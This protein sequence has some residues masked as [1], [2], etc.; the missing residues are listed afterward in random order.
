[1]TTVTKRNGQKQTYDENKVHNFVSNLQKVSPTLH[2]T[3]LSEIFPLQGVPSNV[4]STELSKLA[5]ET[6]AA[7]TTTH[8]QYGDLAGRILTANLHKGVPSTFSAAMQKLGDT[9]LDRDFLD[10]VTANEDELNAMVH[11]ERDFSF[12]VFAFATLERSYLLRNLSDRSVVETPQYLWLRVATA[13]HLPNMQ[14][15]EHTYSMLSTKQFTHATPTLFNSGCRLQQLASCFLLDVEDSIDGIYSTLRDCAVISKNAG[16]LGINISKIRATG[17]PIKG[18]NGVSNGIVPM[19]KVFE[20]T[21]EYC[22][23][24]GGKRK[25][26]CAT[27]IQ[28]HHPDIMDWLMLRR[29]DGIES[30]RCRSLFYGLWTSDLFMKRVEANASWSLIDSTAVPELDTTYGEEFEALYEQA[31]KDGKVVRTMP[32]RELFNTILESQMETGTPYILFKDAANRRNNQKAAGCLT[33]SNLCCEIM[34]YKDQS[35]V[36]VCTLASICLPACVRNGDFDFKHLRHLVATVTENL[37][38]T[39]DRSSYPV[40]QARYG[41]TKRRPIGLGVQGLSDVFQKLSIVF[42]SEEALALDRKIFETIYLQSMRT[43]CDLA[44]KEGAY[45]TFRQSP[46]AQGKFQFNLYENK[47]IDLNF[48]EEWEALRSEVMEHGVR[49]SLLVALMPTA[50]SAQI[51]GNSESFEVRT[52]NCYVRRTLGGEFVVVNPT[53]FEGRKWT[54]AMSNKL[55]EDRG[56]VQNMEE[57]SAHEKAVFRTV[58]EIKMKDH[59]LHAAARQPFV[60]QSQSMNLYFA[61]P[62]KKKLTS[63][64]FYGWRQGLKTGAYYM[65]RK[66]KG[67]MMGTLKKKKGAAGKPEMKCEEEVCVMCSS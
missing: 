60:D 31:E 34:E 37:N 65:R 40:P 61:D 54:E 6:A 13:L 52:S 20:A 57:L 22:D 15:I 67:Q 66:I 12:D 63:A 64:L 7:L 33:G 11:K 43:S 42:G 30:R 51:M 47:T 2:N 58:Y 48:P 16:G 62:S 10:F 8:V 24:G 49:N 23:Q 29:P 19:L 18:T 5:A 28:P 55:I 44:K 50:S 36:A 59:I 27:F 32:A 25:G 4:T 14:K 21:A 41:H 3:D 56:S 35:E 17:T 45:A 53:L 39:I 9:V 46:L 26:S 38:I 1:M